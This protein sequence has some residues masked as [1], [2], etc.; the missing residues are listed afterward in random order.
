M[1][2]NIT[3]LGASYTDVPAVELP[4]TGG[5]TASFTDVTPT[6]A[7]AADVLDGKYFF[8]AQGVLTLG[9]NQGGSGAISVVDTQDSHGGT[10]RTITAVDISDTTATASDVASG[11]YFYTADGTKTAGSAT[12]PTL[13]TKNI[14]AN[15]TYNASSDNADGYSSVTVNV[16]GGGGASNCVTGTFIGTTTNEA[17]D[18]TLNYS[19]SGYPVAVMI[20]PTEGAYNSTS[21]SFYNLVQ[22][23]ASAYFYGSKSQINVSPSYSGTSLNDAMSCYYR[24]KS[25]ASSATSYSGTASNSSRVYNDT[26]ATNSNTDVVK[27]RS[28]NKMSVFIAST[29][30]GF[31]ANIEYTYNIIYSS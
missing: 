29:S 3:L 10:I 30:Y 5:G 4:K 21:G 15:G 7:V 16:S 12:Q 26:N 17:M 8:T 6:T 11:K 25:N 31:A 28:K 13:T 9:T 1:A 14:T 2:Q 23:Y 27:I 24:W 22:Q 18:V 19:G 20:Y